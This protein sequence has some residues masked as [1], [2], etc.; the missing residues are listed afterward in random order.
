MIHLLWPSRRDAERVARMHPVTQ[1]PSPR[2]PRD[3]RSV[4]LRVGQYDGKRLKLYPHNVLY[5]IQSGTW[6]DGLSGEPV[7]ESITHWVVAAEFPE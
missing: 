2:L 1:T 7:R 5:L 3:D 4:L 6:M